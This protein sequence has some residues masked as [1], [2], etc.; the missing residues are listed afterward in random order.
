MIRVNGRYLDLLPDTN[1]VIDKQAKLFEEIDTTQRDFSYTFDIPYTTNNYEILSFPSPDTSGKTIYNDLPCDIVGTD[2][3]P[4]YTGKLRIEK[5]KAR[6]ITASFF[7]GNYNWLSLISG[8]LSDLDFSEYNTD[9]NDTNIIDFRTRTEGITFPLVDLGGL[10]TRSQVW[11]LSEDFTG[12]LYVKTIFRKIFYRSGI[13]FKGDLV[14]D[15]LFNNT[16]I[17]KNNKSLDEIQASSSFVEKTS[18]TTRPTENV[19]YKI[20]FDNDSVA[21]YFDGDNNAYDL[22]GSR[23][24]VPYKMTALVECTLE[25][26]LQDVNYSNRIR[27][28]INGAFTFVDIGL[29]IGGLYNTAVPGD[30]QFFSIRRTL[31]LEAGDI[32]EIYSHWQESTG[33][34]TPISV[35]SGSVK[36]TPVFIYR[37]FGNDL[38]PKWTKKDFVLSVLNL[39]NVIADFDPI[40]KTVTF[41]I[42]EKLRTKTAIN[43]SQY[44]DPST[45]EVDFSEFISA[46]GRNNYLSYDEGDDEDLREYNIKEFVKY[47]A[48]NIPVDNDFIE[49]GKDIIKSNFTSP[50]SYINPIFSASLERL[51]LI[52]LEESENTDF[53][54]VAAG[55]S[56]ASFTISDEFYFVGDLVRI[57]DST[58]PDYNGDWLVYAVGAGTVELSGIDFTE[59]ATG[60]ISRLNHRYTTSDKV[61]ILVNIPDY[62]IANFSMVS[63]WNL[64][65]SSPTALA[66]AY[67]NIL[68]TG[69]TVNDSYLQGLSFGDVGNAKSYQKTLI[70]TYWRTVANILSDPV[71]VKASFRFPQ[72]VFRLL[73]P[74][75]PVY[76]KTQKTT[77]LYYINRIRG[78]KNSH[79]PC[80]VELI[81]L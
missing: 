75:T 17:I 12:A 65:D 63:P 50:I 16:I 81:K 31:T 69:D 58:N 70:D 49:E 52:E 19:D 6:S 68:N 77:N 48:G 44:I 40:S 42:F 9:L 1:I 10:V 5:I 7:S 35:I 3:I 53:T 61:F 66:F 23:Y 72:S 62:N 15:W 21:P 2:G 22:A 36:I 79:L 27:I 67:F 46:F 60:K 24:V 13:K 14:N 56:F 51:N 45:I 25:G 76:L 43:I 64:D 55:G 39:F 20:T 28:Y 71:K 73:T 78:Y 74:L 11:L 18:T 37:V 8:N 33:S 80:E 32:V 57:Q 4:I 30:K 41:N 59:T 29:S 26:S 38:V 54:A 34:T 47:A